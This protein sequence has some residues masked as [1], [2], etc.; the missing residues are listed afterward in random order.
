MLPDAPRYHGLAHGKSREKVIPSPKV[1]NLTT[2]PSGELKA[3]GICFVHQ[4]NLI[5]DGSVH[6][7][8][9]VFHSTSIYGHSFVEHH[10][11]SKL[12]VYA[13]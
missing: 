2:R 5:F 13:S 6:A 4:Q 7:K 11:T 8:L 12:P 1:D 10:S 9:I 3:S